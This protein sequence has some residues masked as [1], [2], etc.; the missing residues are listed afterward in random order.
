MHFVPK[1]AFAI[2]AALAGPALAEADPTAIIRIGS[3]YEPQNLDNT[4]GAGQGSVQ[5]ADS[6]AQGGGCQDALLL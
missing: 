2:A 6:A 4:A 5:T 1:L 3:L